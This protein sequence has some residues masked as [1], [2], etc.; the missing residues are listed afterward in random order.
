MITLLIS[1][2]FFSAFSLS[3]A[4]KVYQSLSTGSLTAAGAKLSTLVLAEIFM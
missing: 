4:E 2:Q 3:S 1:L